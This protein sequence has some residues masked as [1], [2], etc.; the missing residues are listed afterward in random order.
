[1]SGVHGAEDFGSAVNLFFC[2]STL[3]IILII[4]K[5][6][7][8]FFG[9]IAILPGIIIGTVIGAFFG[10]VDFT[11]VLDASWLHLPQVFCFGTPEFHLLPILTMTLVAF[12]SLVESTCVYFALGDI[13]EKK[14]KG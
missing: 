14:I 5:F 4:L 11:P 10:R 9:S 13:T 1:L 12:V 6:A 7:K 3:I 2:F 8:G